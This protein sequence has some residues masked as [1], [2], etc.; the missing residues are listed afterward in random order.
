MLADVL[1]CFADDHGC[2][3]CLQMI[4]DA[5]RCLQMLDDCVQTDANF[6]HK[7]ALCSKWAQ[8]ENVLVKMSSK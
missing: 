8:N 6:A 5:C 1:G 3:I 2:L 4:G 7:C